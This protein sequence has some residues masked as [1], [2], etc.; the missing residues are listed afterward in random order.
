MCRAR[1]DLN[2]PKA[3]QV[4]ETFGI[5]KEAQRAPGAE[6]TLLRQANGPYAVPDALG[7][8]I[9]YGSDRH[10]WRAVLVSGLSPLSVLY[11]GTNIIK[12]NKNRLIV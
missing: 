5:I 2:R 6:L 3:S 12:L 8:G 9:D 10:L 7:V 11:H 1:L 4:F